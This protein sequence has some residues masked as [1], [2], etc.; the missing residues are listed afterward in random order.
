MQADAPLV[1]EA[2]S[3]MGFVITPPILLAVLA[4]LA[5]RGGTL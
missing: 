4:V 3:A 5:A 2:V 1:L